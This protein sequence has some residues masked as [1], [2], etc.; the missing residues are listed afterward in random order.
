M[1]HLFLA[2]AIV[3]LV[4]GLIVRFMARRHR[5]ELGRTIAWYSPKAWF[6]LP[7]DCLTKKGERLQ[8]ISYAMIVV[9]VVLYLIGSRGI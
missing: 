3:L 6:A 2:I 7:S 9:G 8:Q 5:T 1:P 4:S